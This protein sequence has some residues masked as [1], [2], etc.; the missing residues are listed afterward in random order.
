LGSQVTA[1]ANILAIDGQSRILADAFGGDG[2]SIVL[3]R[4]APAEEA[5]G[6]A[7]HLGV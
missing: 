1:A 7:T 2:N 4:Y 6:Q 5:A 3:S